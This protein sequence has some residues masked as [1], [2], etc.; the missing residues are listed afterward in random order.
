MRSLEQFSAQPSRLEGESMSCG[1]PAVKLGARSCGGTPRIGVA[2]EALERRPAAST[3]LS[4]VALDNR[5]DGVA[6][7]IAWRRKAAERVPC[8]QT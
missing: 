3:G 6:G 8:R 1:G 2:L 4:R 5:K 7:S